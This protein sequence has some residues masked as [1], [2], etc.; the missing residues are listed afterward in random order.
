[1]EGAYEGQILIPG[2]PKVI[3]CA[4]LG[5][6]ALALQLWGRMRQGEQDAVLTPVKPLKK[7]A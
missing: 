1:M 2:P 7:W 3:N 4:D 6:L 5:V